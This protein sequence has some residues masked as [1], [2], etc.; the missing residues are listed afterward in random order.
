MSSSASAAPSMIQ[1]IRSDDW[2]TA[3]GQPYG[4]PLT[5]ATG[6][7]AGVAFS[8]DGRLLVTTSADQTR[9]PRPTQVDSVV[10]HAVLITQPLQF[11]LRASAS[12]GTR[13]GS[14]PVGCPRAGGARA[15]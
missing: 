5:R 9:L 1:R 11:V 4:H 15:C 14:H 3:T 13:C 6:A 10:D 2:D 7:V 8:P 12:A